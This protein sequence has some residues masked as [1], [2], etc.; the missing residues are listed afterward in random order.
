MK[1]NPLVKK[2]NKAYFDKMMEPLGVVLDKEQRAAVLCNAPH[3]LI[4]AGA[5]AGKTTTMVAKAKYLVDSGKAKPNE[6]LVISFTNHAVNEFKEKLHKLDGQAKWNVKTFHKLGYLLSNEPEPQAWNILESNRQQDIVG[7]TFKRL[8]E[9]KTFAEYVLLFFGTYFGQPFDDMRTDA[10]ARYFT[11]NQ[12]LRA[13]IDG[14]V[15]KDINEHARRNKSIRYESMRSKEEVRIANW[16]YLHG[17]EYE[18]EKEYPHLIRQSIHPHRPYTPDFFI[19]QGEREAWI[20]HYGITEDG[21]SDKFTKGELEKYLK[22]IGLKAKWHKQ[23]GTT[24]VT[25]YSSYIDEDM[26]PE[27]DLERKLRALGFKLYPKDP[28]EVCR[29]LVEANVNKQFE[30]FTGL[31]ARFISLFKGKNY[32]NKK[33]DEWYTVFE[34]KTAK[35]C[36][37]RKNMQ[38]LLSGV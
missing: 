35:K 25:T 1:N 19:K 24:L 22:Y 26:T 9:D 10:I 31:I 7:E 2:Y 14:Q 27:H 5:G 6:I 28:V 16:L 15:D 21:T 32:G 18:Y 33:W 4:V 3:S 20:E 8:I 30:K 37:V 13:C 12:T 23:F 11:N 36:V 34:K 29:Q 38:G 17:I